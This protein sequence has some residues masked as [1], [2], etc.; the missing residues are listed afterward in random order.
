MGRKDVA[1]LGYGIIIERLNSISN[2]RHAFSLMS[3]KISGHFKEPIQN[4]KRDYTRTRKCGMS[5]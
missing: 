2:R 1:K 5:F 4:L 3:C